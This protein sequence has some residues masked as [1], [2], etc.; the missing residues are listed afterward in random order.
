MRILYSLS[1]GDS[2]G[3]KGLLGEDF[4]AGFLAGLLTRFLAGFLATLA[5]LG[6]LGAAVF[7]GARRFLG[8]GGGYATSPAWIRRTAARV[9]ATMEAVSRAKIGDEG[10][11]DEAAR[12]SDGSNG[13]FCGSEGGVSFGGEGETSFNSNAVGAIASLCRDLGRRICPWRNI[14]PLFTDGLLQD[15]IFCRMEK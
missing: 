1:L 3:E 15:G 10:R 11:K 2:V 9:R 6:G 13:R 5:G 8:A 7:L 14:L 4:L 12:V